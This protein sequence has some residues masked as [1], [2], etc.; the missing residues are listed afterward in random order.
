MYKLPLP[1]DSQPNP[2]QTK[3][4]EYVLA[5]VL[6]AAKGREVKVGEPVALSVEDA[7]AFQAF[8]ALDK[9]GKIPLPGAAAAAIHDAAE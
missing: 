8:A 3:Q 5:K 7:D 9:E 4:D 1:P 2:I 6:E